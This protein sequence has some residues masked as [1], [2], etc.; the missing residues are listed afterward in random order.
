M[1][2]VEN[3]AAAM[4]SAIAKPPSTVNARPKPSPRKRSMK[5]HVSVAAPVKMDGAKMS[6]LAALKLKQMVSYDCTINLYPFMPPNLVLP[7]FRTP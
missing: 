7:S 2:D 3:T 6:E 4:N 1:A 5:K